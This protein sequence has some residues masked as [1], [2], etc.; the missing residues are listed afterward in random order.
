MLTQLAHGINKTIQLMLN[1]STVMQTVFESREWTKTTDILK[2]IWN[3]SYKL[4]LSFSHFPYVNTYTNTTQQRE[5]RCLRKRLMMMSFQILPNSAYFYLKEHK[6]LI[7]INKILQG[8]FIKPFQHIV[9][10][11]TAAACCISSALKRIAS[12]IRC[13]SEEYNGKHWH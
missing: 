6:I 7:T 11:I 9:Q 12:R 8:I 4:V 10:K 3:L 5:K 13:M 1:L 2:I